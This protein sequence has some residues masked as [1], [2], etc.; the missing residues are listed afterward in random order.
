VPSANVNTLDDYKEGTWTPGVAF[1]GNSVGVTYAVW[2]SGSYTKI[3][4]L[5]FASG[6]FG[7]TSKGTSA[8]Q[9]TVTGLP[10][11][12]N[13]TGYYLPLLRMTEVIFTGVFMG[14]AK[15]LDTIIY[16]DTMS[17]AGV[18]TDLTNAHFSDTSQVGVMIVYR[19]A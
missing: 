12:V 13:A 5:V 18:R 7:L 16:L 3:G 2:T 8:G 10:Y 19:A 11:A 6:R 4:N 9:A 14:E 17:D 15:S 1:G